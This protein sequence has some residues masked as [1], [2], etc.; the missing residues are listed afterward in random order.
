LGFLDEKPFEKVVPKSGQ[1]TTFFRSYFHAMPLVFSSNGA[2][3]E[4]IDATNVMQ[5]K[6]HKGQDRNWQIRFQD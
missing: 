4:S 5:Y 6:G 1:R 3:P 2:P